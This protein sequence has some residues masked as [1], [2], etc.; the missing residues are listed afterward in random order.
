MVEEPRMNDVFHA[1]AHQTRRA[2][3]SRLASGELT[4]SL[5]ERLKAT[6]C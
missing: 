4:V 3:L 6:A 2:M 5:I 1:L